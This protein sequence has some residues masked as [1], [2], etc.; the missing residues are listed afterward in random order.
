HAQAAN[1]PLVKIKAIPAGAIMGMPDVTSSTSASASIIERICDWRG[2]RW[3]G[4]RAAGGDDAPAAFLW[5]RHRLA[6]S[7][8]RLDPGAGRRSGLKRTGERMLGA[9][10]RHTDEKIWHVVCV[11]TILIHDEHDELVYH[12]VLCKRS[13][14][15]S[16]C[17]PI[18]GI[19]GPS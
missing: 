8:L 5:A 6:D 1:S 14:S 18:L 19:G 10:Q 2:E 9:A 17:V 12:C 13:R 4:R 11:R 3:R 15:R 16:T 7:R